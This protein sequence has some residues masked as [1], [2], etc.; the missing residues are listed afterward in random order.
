MNKF[1][2]IEAFIAV[3]EENSFAAAARKLKQSTAAISRQVSR[4]EVLL[5]VE[6]LYRTTRKLMLTDLG[7]EY[8]QQSKK[9]IQG[10]IEAE[11]TLSSSLTEAVGTL[12]IST[13][14]FFAEEYLS[15]GL[16]RFLKENPKL[17][18][19]IRSQER[20]PD[21][22]NEDIDLIFGMNLQ[23]PTEYVQKSISKTRYVLCASPNYLQEH[24]TPKKPEDL[25]KHRF[26]GHTSRKQDNNLVF[27]RGREVFIEKVLWSN[28]TYVMRRYAEQN[29]GLVRLHDYFVKEAIFEGRLIEVL[30]EY[31]EPYVNIYLYYL[32]TRYLQPKIRRFIDFFCNKQF[33]MSDNRNAKSLN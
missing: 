14:R 1:D 15:L 33:G 31:K 19:N 2:Y 6:L 11:A 10:L 25:I 27:G 26:I 8:Y 22:V 29:L 12:N 23:G 20:L 30:P 7:R 21:L 3:V 32:Q 17:E 24:G 13:V 18:I 5:G 16:A 9:A 28:D 4:L